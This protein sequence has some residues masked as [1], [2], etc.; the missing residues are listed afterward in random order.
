MRVLLYRG[1]GRPAA[2]DIHNSY[3]AGVGV[4]SRNI[5]SHRSCVTGKGGLERRTLRRWGFD[6]AVAVVA[7]TMVPV[8][9]AIE[10]TMATVAVAGHRVASVVAVGHREVF[11]VDTGNFGMEVA[12]H[13]VL[14]VVTAL[15]ALLHSWCKIVD[16]Q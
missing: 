8:V 6:F 11:A 15:P 7:H 16:R 2:Q 13:T 10:H 1:I 9:V 4:Y 14:V 12:L 5:F 3:C